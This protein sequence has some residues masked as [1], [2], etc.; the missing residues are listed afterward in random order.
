MAIVLGLACS[1]LHAAD[2]P[3]TNPAGGAQA[4]A[5]QK[6]VSP[7]AIA[8]LIAQLDADQYDQRQAAKTKL[9]AIGKPAIPAL[10]Q[11]ASGDSLEVTT[12][13]VGLLG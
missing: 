8:K 1:L 4:A 6:T 10:A 13:A 3:A 11:A 5:S 9:V 12:T 2:N 7:E